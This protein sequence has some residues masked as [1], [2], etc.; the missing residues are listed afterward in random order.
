MFVAAGLLGAALGAAG[1]LAIRLFFPAGPE[2]VGVRVARRVVGPDFLHWAAV[3]PPFLALLLVASA[4]FASEFPALPDPVP[5]SSARSW[6]PVVPCPVVP[7]PVGSDRF[8]PA[9]PAGATSWRARAEELE[10]RVAELERRLDLAGPR[11]YYPSVGLCAAP[12]L[13]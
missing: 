5:A 7:L 4:A 9:Y 3:R 12:E 11:K 2:G 1:G 13:R 8:R 6:S 10:R